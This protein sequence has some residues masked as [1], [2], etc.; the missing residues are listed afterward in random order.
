M[1]ADNGAAVPNFTLIA[2]GLEV[3]PA[4]AELAALPDYYWLEINE[5]PSVYVRLLDNHGTPVLTA[6]LP[7]TWRL[8]DQVRAILAGRHD[9]TGSFADCRVGL[10]PPG[11][12][13]APHHDGI[14][15]IKARRYQ[16]ALQSAPGVELMVRRRAETPAPGRGLADR[17]EPHPQRLQSQPGRSHHDPVRYGRGLNRGAGP[18]GL[19]AAVGLHHRKLVAAG[20][21]E[22]EAP[23]AGEGEDRAH[24]DAAGR[25]HRR[26]R[27]L[28]IVDL[29]HRQRRR[30]SPRRHRP[31]GR[32]R[33]RRS[34]CRHRSARKPVSAQPNAAS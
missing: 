4:L 28:Q 18:E 32:Y 27:R 19:M 34:A 22:L 14:D 33:C 25:R 6:E 24:H 3:A 9:D 16:L 26:Q 8:I 17:G 13:L 1:S 20:I 31:A 2:D 12:G 5:A 23:A 10:M 29:D 15:G 11:E 21:D 7:Q 30:A